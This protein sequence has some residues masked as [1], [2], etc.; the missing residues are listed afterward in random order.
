M[1][2]QPSKTFHEQVIAFQVTMLIINSADS[3][4]SF[5][6]ALGLLVVH[7]GTS[8]KYRKLCG[9]MLRNIV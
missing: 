6:I 7:I 3:F 9:R 2:V 1:W 5:P 8:W 4:L